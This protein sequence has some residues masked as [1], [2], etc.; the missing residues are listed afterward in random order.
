MPFCYY[1]DTVISNWFGGV[2]CPDQQQYGKLL[3]LDYLPEPYWGN[4]DNCSFVIVNYNPGGGNNIDPHTYIKYA[5]CSCNVPTLIKEVLT[6]S[7][8]YV[9]LPFPLLM[10][11]NALHSKGWDWFDTY[12]GYRWWQQKK[13]WFNHLATAANVPTIDQGL[14]PFAIELCPWHSPSWPGT[15][16][17][18]KS[19]LDKV[20]D[21]YVIAPIL[22]AI[23]KSSSKLAFFIGSGHIAV[24]NHWGFKPISCIIQPDPKLKRFYQ[25]FEYQASGL[26]AIVTWANGSNKY[27]STHFYPYEVTMISNLINNKYPIFP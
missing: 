2:F 26:K 12:G 18:L 4:P 11:K 20:I 8:S 17:L 7:Y 14:M 25:A 15:G 21:K 27:P 24:L 9:A 10:D 1:W 16:A 6:N 22:Y 23:N 5:S 3:N 13:N 19:P